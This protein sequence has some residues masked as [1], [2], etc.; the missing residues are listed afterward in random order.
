LDNFRQPR[1]PPKAP[2]NSR[3]DSID[4]DA[5]IE[6]GAVGANGRTSPIAWICD[7][8]SDT[9][10]SPKERTKSIGSTPRYESALK[11]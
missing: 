5:D 4:Y 10:G 3:Y 2:G 7:T 1:R 11:R 6:N 8:Y 9:F